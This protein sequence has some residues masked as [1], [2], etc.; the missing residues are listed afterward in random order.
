MKSALLQTLALTTLAPLAFAAVVNNS[1]PYRNGSGELQMQMWYPEESTLLRGVLVMAPGLG[2]DARGA[3]DEAAE[4]ALFKEV[5]PKHGFALIG[6]RFSSGNAFNAPKPGGWATDCSLLRE[7]LIKIAT[8]SGHP[9]LT[10]VPM[11]VYGFSNRAITLQ[12]PNYQTLESATTVTLSQT[13]ARLTIEPSSPRVVKG[14][15]VQFSAAGIDQFGA[16]IQIVPTRKTSIGGS[17]AAAPGRFTAG[18]KPCNCRVTTTANDK[19][20]STLITVANP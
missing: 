16:P 19:A 8:T 13:T 20:R 17:I 3:A 15:T 14:G 1:L 18:D 5:A 2:S 10:T 7:G 12:H 11:A 4:D 6:L 9:E